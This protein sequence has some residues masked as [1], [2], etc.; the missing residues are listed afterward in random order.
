MAHVLRRGILKLGLIAA[1]ALVASPLTYAAEKTLKIGAPLPLTGPLS[2]EGTRQQNGFQLW[3]DT[4]NAAGGIKVGNDTYKV[5]MVYVDYQSNTPRAVQAAERLITQDKV[6]FLFGPFGSGA[7]K[8][9]SAITEKYGVPMIAPNAAS[10][11]VYDQGFKYLFGVYSPNQTLTEPVAEI[12]AKEHPEIKKVAIIARND[13]FPLAIAEEMEKSVTKRGLEI[14]SFE[15]YAIGTL[16]FSSSLTKLRASKPDWI[17]VTGYVNDLILAREQMAELGVTGQI[18]SM[19]VGPL[20]PAFKEGVGEL[21]NN[22]TTFAWWDASAKYQGTDIF[23]TPA[24]FV[25]LYQKA[26]NMVPEYSSAGSAACGAILQLAIEST[27]TIDRA[28]VRD[29]L[30]NMDAM[31]FWG[32]V[33]FG[34]TG[35][36]TSLKPPLIQIQDDTPEVLYPPEI[37]TSE[38]RLGF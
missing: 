8:A 28:K 6:D 10:E 7:V 36:I 34:P 33:K 27:G 35:Q 5:E 11:Q 13:L 30:A 25:E 23:G 21:T 38:L 19:I 32:P 4:A 31:T 22:V 12:V 3:A 26:Y 2:P 14:V 17:V 37:K 15:K 29:A 1:I 20:D 24:K 9:V 18:L 16:D